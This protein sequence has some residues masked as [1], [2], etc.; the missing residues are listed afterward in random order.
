MG[1]LAL[2]LV[3]LALL[4]SCRTLSPE[5]RATTET[6]KLEVGLDLA[7]E[8]AIRV[9]GERGYA[10]QVVDRVAGIVETDWLTTNPE[11]AASIFV[12]EHQDRYSECGKPG[13]GRAFRAK[14]TRLKVRLSPGS[15]DETD[16]RIDAGFR[17]QGYSHFLFFWG[18]QPLGESPCRSRGR[19]EEE[20][21]LQMKLRTLGEQLQRL[22]RGTP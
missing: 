4:A 5:P 7:C 16:L 8:A 11:Y 21:A 14:Q 10:L 6:L 12:T 19:L 18:M 22:R 13:L 15:R 17:T 3:A 20:L 9:L 1:H 2:I